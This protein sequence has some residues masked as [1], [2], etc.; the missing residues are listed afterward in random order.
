MLYFFE[1]VK[2][3]LPRSKRNN[4]FCYSKKANKVIILFSK[5]KCYKILII[6]HYLEALDFMSATVFFFLNDLAIG[7]K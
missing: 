1:Y 5:V 2:G 7:I 3:F 6:F 4:L